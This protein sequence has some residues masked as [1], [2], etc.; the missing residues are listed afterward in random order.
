LKHIRPA[1]LNKRILY[2][3]NDLADSFV[4]DEKNFSPVNLPV[5]KEKIPE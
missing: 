1:S 3:L 5:N 2:R 4:T